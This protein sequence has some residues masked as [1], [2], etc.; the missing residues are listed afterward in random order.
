MANEATWDHLRV[1]IDSSGKRHAW[2]SLECDRGAS[3][4][5][6]PWVSWL[7]HGRMRNWELLDEPF[8]GEEGDSDNWDFFTP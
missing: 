2:T 8:R 6:N 7:Y 3:V 1:E 4:E 5:E